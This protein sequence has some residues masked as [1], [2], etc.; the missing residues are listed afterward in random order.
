MRHAAIV[1][2]V[3]LAIRLAYLPVRLSWPDAEF[4]AVDA[5]FHDYWA[6]GLVTGEWGP[7]GGQIVGEAPGIEARP[8]FRPPGYPWFLAALYAVAGRS[9]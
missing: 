8:C 3:A 9:A 6:W 5:A 4:P 7:P 1:F 2:T